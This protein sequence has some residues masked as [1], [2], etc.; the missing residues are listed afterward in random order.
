MEQKKIQNNITMIDLLR[1][2]VQ[3]QKKNGIPSE[4]QVIDQ[5]ENAK[6]AKRFLWLNFILI[7][8]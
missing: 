6:R 3:I 1:A 4:E 2:S 8:I 7:L 5:I